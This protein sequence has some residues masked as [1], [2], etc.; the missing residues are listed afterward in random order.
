M[1][2][3]RSWQD[4]CRSTDVNLSE[5]ETDKRKAQAEAALTNGGRHRMGPRSAHSSSAAAATT[6]DLPTRVDCILNCPSASS[7]KDR[8]S[9][10]FFS[11]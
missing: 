7:V 1:R 10:L 5:Q 8:D 4:E 9:G 2:Q 3:A 6:T 11:S